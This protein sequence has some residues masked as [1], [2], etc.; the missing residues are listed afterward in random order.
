MISSLHRMKTKEL[1]QKNFKPLERL[2]KKYCFTWVLK[3]N[4]KYLISIPKK[5][6][7]SIETIEITT[8]RRD[9][10]FNLDGKEKFALELKKDNFGFFSV[11][12]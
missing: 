4:G 5:G 12:E 7:W 10:V 2:F 3:E 11:Y 6:K 8:E 9:I 1:E